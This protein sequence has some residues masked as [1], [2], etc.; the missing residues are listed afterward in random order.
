MPKVVG[1]RDIA[2]RVIVNGAM[3]DFNAEVIDEFR[4]NGG[5]VGGHFEG[6][7]LLILHTVGRRTGNLRLKPLIYAT[8]GTSFLVSGSYGGAEKDPV[9][10]ANVEAMPT[11]T[12]ELADR[13][14][15]AKVSVLREG[16]ERDSGYAKLVA[17]WP[18][19]LKY[20]TNTTRRFPVIRLD[21]TD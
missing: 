18:D 15:T 2:L 1:T 5:L 7:H 10:V 17:Y 9:W 16:P 3:S 6:K 21:P 8:D 20:E 11:V 19:F 12:I 4:N 13:T 14:L